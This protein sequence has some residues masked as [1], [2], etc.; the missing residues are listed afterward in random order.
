MERFWQGARHPLHLLPVVIGGMEHPK[1]QVLNGAI[2][3][4]PQGCCLSISKPPPFF[5]SMLHRH[6][7]VDHALIAGFVP[8]DG[9]NAG[10]YKAYSRTHINSKVKTFCNIILAPSRRHTILIPFNIPAYA[11]HRTHHVFAGL[12]G[13]CD[14]VT[15]RRRQ[16]GCA[17]TRHGVRC[18]SPLIFPF[19]CF[20]ETCQRRRLLMSRF[21]FHSSQ[22][23]EDSSSV[24]HRNVVHG[25]NSYDVLCAIDSAL[26]LCF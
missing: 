26:L 18:T 16:G 21:Q 15:R 1:A 2:A 3:M 19:L 23:I 14:Q 6:L 13:R 5:F 10:D 20:R 22:Q 8:Q 24:L 11:C 9:P 12:L 17:D 25:R 4:T 7:L